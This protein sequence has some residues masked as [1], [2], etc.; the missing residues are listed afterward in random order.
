MQLV[1]ASLHNVVPKSGVSAEYVR[2]VYR[3]G[4]AFFG[5]S[6]P[7]QRVSRELLARKGG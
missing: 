2:L 1:S 5:Q 3:S 7:S 6:V 4:N